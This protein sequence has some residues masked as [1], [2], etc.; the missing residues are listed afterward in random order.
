M[1]NQ[2]GISRDQKLVVCCDRHY[3][4]NFRSNQHGLLKLSDKVTPKRRIRGKTK[5]TD[6]TDSPF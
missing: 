1:S 5:S 4:V 2:S 3:P 6:K